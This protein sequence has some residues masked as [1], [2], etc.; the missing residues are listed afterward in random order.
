MNNAPK[1]RCPFEPTKQDAFIDMLLLCIENALFSM[2]IDENQHLI[3]LV[4]LHY[5]TKNCQS[6]EKQFD[7]VRHKRLKM[8]LLRD[9][10]RKIFLGERDFSQKHPRFL[11]IRSKK[12][13]FDD[14]T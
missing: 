1:T 10:S 13:P 14:M 12:P 7:S 3:L 11:K 8:A 5:N 4:R 9:F 6:K 2:S